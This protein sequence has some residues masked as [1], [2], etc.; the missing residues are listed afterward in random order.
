MVVYIANQ[1]HKNKQAFVSPFAPALSIVSPHQLVKRAS[2]AFTNA[3]LFPLLQA[4]H[5]RSVE[6]AGVD[7]NARVAVTAL[8][9]VSLGFA[10]RCPMACIGVKNPARFVQTARRLTAARVQIMSEDTP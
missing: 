9:A 4:H 7:G 8:D 1:D 6:L 2:S 5:I 3:A 10:V